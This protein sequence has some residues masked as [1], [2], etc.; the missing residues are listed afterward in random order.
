MSYIGN[1]PVLNT[2]EFREEFAVTSTQTVF[3]TSGFVTNTNSEFLEVYRNGVLLSKDDYTLDAD[4][5]TI[6]LNNAAVSGDIVVVTG[7]RDITKRQTELGEYIEEF[8]ISGTPT[9]VTFSYPLNATNT[10]VFLN[11]VKLT[12]TGGSPDITSINAA[13][14]VITFASALANGDVVTVVSRSAV[15]VSHDRV[16]HY[17]TVS[18]DVTVPV[19]QNVAFFGDTE[20]AGTNIIYGSLV[21]AGGAANFSGTTNIHGTFNAVG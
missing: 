8:T 15:L 11:G 1:Q 13:T 16:S 12:T 5:A 10:H 20:L 18:D 14:G 9:T 6:T 17:S 19:G 3:N 7:R 4:A 2:S 21:V